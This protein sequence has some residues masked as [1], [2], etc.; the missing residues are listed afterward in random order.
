MSDPLESRPPTIAVVGAGRCD[1]AT[2]ARAEAV[3]RLL[4]RA[5]AT[6]VTG[7]LG[8]VME[9]ASRGAKEAGGLV[10]AIIPGDE[11]PSATAPADVVIATGIGEARNAIIVN[12]ADA[13]VAVGGE[14]G[15]LSE[16]ALAR[17]RHKPTV[18]LGSW[19]DIPGVMV[20]TTPEDAVAIVLAA[21]GWPADDA[22]H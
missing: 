11:P 2:G 19:D 17:K 7:G 16:I 9:A 22:S 13:L 15:T 14:F 21:V 5:G 6:I 20:A 10:V 8:G 18:T 1:A 3:G 12:T 4:A